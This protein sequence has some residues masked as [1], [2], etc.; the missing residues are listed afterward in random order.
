MFPGSHD[1]GRAGG[2]GLEQ[3]LAEQRL[4]AGADDMNVQLKNM[5]LCQDR[6][7]ECS[8]ACAVSKGRF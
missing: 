8:K 7:L 2:V 1:D 5:L 6:V 3:R 4:D